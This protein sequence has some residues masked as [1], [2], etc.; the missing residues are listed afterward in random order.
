MSTETEL[1]AILVGP[2]GTEALRELVK[3]NLLKRSHGSRVLQIPPS[4]GG[5]S[6]NYVDYTFGNK[7]EAWLL[8]TGHGETYDKHHVYVAEVVDRNG[9][10]YQ[11]TISLVMKNRKDGVFVLARRRR[12]GSGLNLARRPTPTSFMQ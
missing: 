11:L 7:R 1:P 4:I 5:I 12:L 6:I 3:N 10:V 8:K 9:V 2:E